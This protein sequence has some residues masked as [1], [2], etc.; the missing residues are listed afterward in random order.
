MGGSLCLED[1]GSTNE[2]A[3]GNGDLEGG[4]GTLATGYV[5]FLFLS[6]LDLR[7]YH[8]NGRKM[9]TGTWSIH[10]G[11]C[12][13]VLIFLRTSFKIILSSSLIQVLK[14]IFDVCSFYENRYFALS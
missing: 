1:I 3:D 2:R 8:L 10:V 14:K 11:M 7:I 4:K 12:M 9:S 5:C 13:I 6:E